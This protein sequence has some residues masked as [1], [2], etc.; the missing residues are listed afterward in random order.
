MKPRLILLCKSPPEL[1]TPVFSIALALARRMRVCLVTTACAFSAREALEQAGVEVV[2]TGD[3]EGADFFARAGRAFLFRRKA[4]EFL[5]AQ[6]KDPSGIRLWVGSGDTAVLLGPE[7]LRA[8]PFVLQLHELYD[9]N[10]VY[11]HLLGPLARRAVS[12]VVPESN[13]ADIVRCWYQL[14]R[15]PFVI[16]NKPWYHPR[17]RCLAVHAPGAKSVLDALAGRKIVLYQG[18]IGPLRDIRP[19][20]KAVGNM[21]SRW[22]FLAMGR[23]RHGFVPAIRAQ[24]P[25][26][27]HIGHLGAP[28]HLEIT[29]HAHIG[30]AVYGFDML[31]AVFCAPN[32]IWEYSGFGIPILCQDLPGLRSTVGAAQAGLCLDTTNPAQVERAIETIDDAYPDMSANASHFFE[33]VDIEELALQALGLGTPVERQT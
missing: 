9:T 22:A 3:V 20:A 8:E 4:C 28:T 15:A 24:A 6:Q 17:T 32:K 2:A 5:F 13:R 21:G 1:L 31:N 10:P 33:S 27:I 29:S 12:V 19:I 26:T 14:D 16:P 11:L 25:N 23:D 7:L 18:D 30:V